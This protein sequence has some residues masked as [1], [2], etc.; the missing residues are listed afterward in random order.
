MA[1]QLAF[2][3]ALRQRGAV[4]RD[5]QAL[6]SPGPVVQS[7]SH[8]LLSAPCLALDQHR[9]PGVGDLGNLGHQLK[10]RWALPDHLGRAAATGSLTSLEKAILALELLLGQLE[11]MDEPCVRDC[12]G[13]VR[14]EHGDGIDVGR[15][16]HRRRR[17]IVDLQDSDDLLA[18]PERNSDRAPDAGS[19]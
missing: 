10:K 1:E 2:E 6:P 19:L 17:T 7:G 16:E 12:Q 11:S 13:R 9:H 3:E 4:L 8:Q 14:C 18:L 5:E 15:C